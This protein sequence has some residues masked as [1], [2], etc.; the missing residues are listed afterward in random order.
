[1]RPL[2]PQELL[3]LEPL[4]QTAIK[5]PKSMLEKIDEKSRS[6]LLN[7]SNWIRAALYRELVRKD[8]PND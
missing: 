6:K 1:M 4:I 3:A 7:R 2:P 8:K 5:L